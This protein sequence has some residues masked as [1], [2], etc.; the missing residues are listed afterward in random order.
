MTTTSGVTAGTKEVA[1]KAGNLGKHLG[2]KVAK[3]SKFLK[4]LFVRSSTS[5]QAGTLGAGSSKAWFNTIKYARFGVLG[6]LLPYVFFKFIGNIRNQA[7]IKQ[8][9]HLDSTSYENTKKKR[10]YNTAAVGLGMGAIGSMLVG[11]LGPI[12]IGIS[13]VGA[14]LT[15]KAF[16]GFTNDA[17]LEKAGLGAALVA[18]IANAGGLLGGAMMP[19]LFVGAALYD[20]VLSLYE[21]T[22]S[23]HRTWLSGILDLFYNNGTLTGWRDNEQ[24]RLPVLYQQA[25]VEQKRKSMKNSGVREII[26]DYKGQEYLNRYQEGLAKIYD[27]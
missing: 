16:A 18:A 12:G 17:P 25:I 8:G 1:Q 9:V 20:P 13:A 10:E 14:L 11:T 22:M 4:D 19:L 24:G 2:D 7:K 5:I 23:G 27:S 6:L 15:A 21:R 3:G 26:I